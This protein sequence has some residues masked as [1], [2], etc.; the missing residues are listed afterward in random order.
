MT[1]YEAARRYTRAGLHILPIKGDGSKAPS[2]PT[3]KEYQERLP[4]EEEL[5][6][7]FEGHERG[8]A[9]LG[10]HGLEVLDIERRDTF[11]AFAAAVEKE[12]PGLI[13]RLTRVQ[14]PGKEGQ[15]GDHLYYRCEAAGRSQTL[16]SAKK[17]LIE[18]RG[19]GGYVVAPPSPA[20]CH[21]TNKP[22]VHISG[23]ALPDIPTIT[24][25]E[26]D[27]LLC[28]ARSFDRRLRRGEEFI[29][30]PLLHA[31]ARVGTTPPSRSPV[32]S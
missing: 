23:P 14:T 16:A 32:T 13:G 9:I 25:A 29:D 27:L 26:R 30:R 4:T 19:E 1:T 28:V 31:P 24:P 20:Q 10:G 3:W 22:Y 6:V 12:A 2:L 11:E 8:L 7:W 21:P 17:K 18:T 5:H 15:P